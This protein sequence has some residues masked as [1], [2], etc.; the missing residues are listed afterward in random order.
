MPDHQ[1]YL[2]LGDNRWVIAACSCDGWRQEKMLKVGQRASDLVRELEE[3][4]ERHAGQ[5]SSPPYTP[6]LPTG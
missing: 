1:L 6:A 3:E 4:F 5:A 2:N